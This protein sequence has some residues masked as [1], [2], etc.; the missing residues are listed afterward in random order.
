[1]NCTNRCLTV[2]SVIGQ[3]NWEVVGCQMVYL[4]QCS[5]YSASA[6]PSH[7]LQDRGHQWVW[8][9]YHRP[10][11]H[12]VCRVGQGRGASVRGWT[13]GA[14]GRYLWVTQLFTLWFLLSPFTLRTYDFLRM[15]HPL[16]IFVNVYLGDFFTVRD[17]KNFDLINI[18]LFWM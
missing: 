9:R 15:I 1:M 7:Q 10:C 3:L 18:Q 14:S 13:S 16:A 4:I 12:P 8:P 2:K 11:Q 6:Y 17:V 5:I